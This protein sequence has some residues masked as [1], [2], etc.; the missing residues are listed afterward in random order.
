MSK[1]TDLNTLYDETSNLSKSILKDI[2]NIKQS[3]LR[4]F[5]TPKGSVPFNRQYGTSL[6]SLLFEND[7]D[8]ADITMFLYMDIT[9]W[10]PRVELN[11]NDITITK[12]DANTYSVSCYFRV[13]SLTE[14]TSSVS[15][16]ISDK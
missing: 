5:M 12:V 3:L 13:P 2:N 8:P 1:Y 15:V 10:E 14:T 16:T 6:R 7:V 11:P 4:L 9:D